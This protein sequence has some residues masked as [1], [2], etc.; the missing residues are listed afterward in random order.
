MNTQVTSLLD[1]YVYAIRKLLPR[2][3]RNDI[4]SE[5]REILQ[6]QVDDE[7]ARVRRPLLDE[8]IEAILKRFGR[9]REVASH[10]GSRQYLIGP[11]VFGSYVVAVKVVLWFMVPVTLFMVLLNG[12]TARE[13]LFGSLLE[14]IWTSVSIAL[15]NLGMVTI[16]FVYFGR[17]SSEQITDEDWH[18]EDLP[19][20]PA[21]P[22]APLSKSELVGSMVGLALM[23]CWWLGVNA[24]LRR[25][26]GW[27]PLP[28][29]WSTIW[30]E[31]T[32]AAV[33]VLTCEH[34]AGSH[35]SDT[36]TLDQGL[37]GCGLHP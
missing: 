5:L 23:L 9:P 33:L 32:V 28:I 29:V 27:D 36:S 19:E 31:V 4:A 8:E 7:E 21:D 24:Y 3:Q 17:K 15:F 22:S 34:R 14:A 10:Y 26:I 37:P 12:A 13:H 20:L 35:R 16:L 6:S 1:R 30:A 25:W 11:E 18:L 2:D